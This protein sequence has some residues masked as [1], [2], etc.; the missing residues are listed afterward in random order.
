M[1]KPVFSTA[2]GQRHCAVTSEV[3]TLRSVLVHRPGRELARLTPGNVHELLFDELVWLKQAQAEHDGLVAVLRHH[4][5]KVTLLEE[6]LA[7]TLRDSGAAQDI[8]AAATSASRLGAEFGSDLR[9]WLLTVEPRELASMLIAG[10]T[11]AE[12][13]WAPRGL[14]GVRAQPDTLLLEPL[15]NHLFVRDSSMWMHGGVALGHMRFTARRREHDHLAAIYR[16]HPAF[17]ATPSLILHD[18]GASPWANDAFIEGGDVMVLA[19][20]VLLIAVSQRTNWQGVEAL[21]HALAEHGELD[22]AFII[23]LPPGRTFMHLDTVI[24]QADRDLFVVFAPLL[25]T[26][27]PIRVRSG[28]RGRLIWEPVDDLFAGLAQALQLNRVRIVET[29]GDNVRAQREQWDDANNL[30][31]LAPGVVVAYE[32]NECTNQRLRE[33]GVTVVEIAGFELGRGRGGPHCMTCPLERD[34]LPSPR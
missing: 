14:T 29:G 16:Y 10:L 20:R 11:T 5:V 15:V 31:A 12:L 9:A 13:P 26:L 22:H 24:T 2:Q 4:G 33:A 21:L 3:G 25:P 23:E 19:A 30:L 32:R 34:D 28:A 8:L 27:R 6:L 1:T 18:A 7:E 17:A